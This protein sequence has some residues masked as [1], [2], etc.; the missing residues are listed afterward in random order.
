MTTDPIT[1]GDS[2][3]CTA[4]S[5]QDGGAGDK[6]PAGVGARAR[7]A[8]QSAPTQGDAP[9]CADAPVEAGDAAAEA[10]DDASEAVDDAGE[11]VELGPLLAAQGRRLADGAV[12]LA[13]RLAAYWTPPALL[14][15]P[16]PPVSE[17][18]SYAHAGAWA[19]KNGFVRGC[20]I[21]WWRL[22]ALPVT[23][24]CRLREWI[25]QRPGRAFA[26]L[27]LVALLARTTPGRVVVDGLGWVVSRTAWLLLAWTP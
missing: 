1:G 19:P 10:V 16:A 2:A 11:A 8:V 7:I 21:A 20:G 4:Q 24:R 3:L 6:A 27:L 5:D 12:R 14:T 26:A 15:E 25:W 23:V 13:D 18:A 22:V 9:A 17:L